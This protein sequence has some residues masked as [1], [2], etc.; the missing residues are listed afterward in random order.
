MGLH[1]GRRRKCC[2]TLDKMLY[3]QSKPSKQTFEQR[4]PNAPGT[5]AAEVFSLEVFSLEV[6]DGRRGRIAASFADRSVHVWSLSSTGGFESAFT[7][8][9]EG[10]FIPRSLFFSPSK[11]LYVFSASG[12]MVYVLLVSF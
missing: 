7:V 3:A 4:R 9:M 12:G 5:P 1:R 8:T 6:E 11:E 2:C 10:G